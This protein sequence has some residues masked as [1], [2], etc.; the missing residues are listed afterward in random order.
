MS[1]EK[2][3]HNHTHEMLRSIRDAQH[4]LMTRMTLLE[5]AIL[6][7]DHGLSG[8]I[9]NLETAFR[10]ELRKVNETLR[11]HGEAGAGQWDDLDKLSKRLD[12]A[13]ARLIALETGNTP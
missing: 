9:D 6:T 7:L 5:R 13:L 10:A 2:T 4:M 11:N 1:D 12:D 8:R 3:L